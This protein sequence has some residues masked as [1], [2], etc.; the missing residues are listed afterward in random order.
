MYRVLPS[1]LLSL[2]TGGN[3]APAS[4]VIASGS[5]V[6]P[7]RIGMSA[8]SVPRAVRVISDR[9]EPDAEGGKQRVIRFSISGAKAEAE[10]QDGKVWRI[11]ILTPGIAIDPGI[12]VGSPLKMLLGLPSLEGELAEGA[13]FVW[14]KSLC[15]RSFR[16]SYEPNT[17]SDYLGAW[18]E[19]SLKSLPAG[20]KVQAILVVGCTK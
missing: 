1:L 6:G 13:L 20:V 15:G 14:S 12:E 3:A 18:N 4:Q 7:V 10:I 5:G 11:Q 2:V 8:Q 19:T 9:M 16:L 17:D